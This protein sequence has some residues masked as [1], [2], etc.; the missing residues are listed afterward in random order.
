M[1]QISTNIHSSRRKHYERLPR[2]TFQMTERAECIMSLL[3]SFRLLRTTHILEFLHYHF[4]DNH[5]HQRTRRVLRLLHD[6]ERVLRIRN[7][8]LRDTVTHGSLPKIYGLNIRKNHALNERYDKASRVVPHTLSVADTIIFNVVRACRADK[9]TL[10]FMAHQEILNTL[11]PEHTRRIKK[12]LTWSVQTHFHHTNHTFH[13]TPDQLFIVENKDG[14]R[15]FLLEEDL[16][17]EPI[18]RKDLQGTA[19]YRKLLAYGFSRARALLLNRFGIAR[20][21]V[22]FV[23]NSAERA[24]HMLAMYEPLNQELQEAGFKKCPA[25]VFLFIDR[26]TLRAHDIFTAPWLNAK[27]D[28]YRIEI[29]RT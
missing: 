17:S 6:H 13:I 25:N 1:A 18:Q 16:Q 4:G 12:P 20:F 2:G 23:T 9:D 8:P 28:I 29:P 26:P 11:A 22:L 10:R 14:K 19:I 27:G 5:S 24:G 21:Q 3:G 7:D 15:A